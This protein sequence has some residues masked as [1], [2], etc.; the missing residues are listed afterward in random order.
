[1]H[2]TK[3]F[4]ESFIQLSLENELQKREYESAFGALLEEG[5]L[6]H[7]NKVRVLSLYVM[8]NI[9]MAFC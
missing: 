5:L 9:D 2:L 8:N 6:E 3:K 4:E 7:Y 1:M